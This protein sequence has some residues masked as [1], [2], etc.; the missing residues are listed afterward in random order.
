MSLEYCEEG[1][2]LEFPDATHWLH[3]EDPEEIN[4]ALAEFFAISS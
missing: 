1:R 2:L 4:R 3:H